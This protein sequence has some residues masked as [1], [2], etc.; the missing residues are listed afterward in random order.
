MKKIRYVNLELRLSE[1][2]VRPMSVPAW[3]VPL[4]EAVH[5]RGA[6]KQFGT[7][8]V[9]AV[10]KKRTARGTVE[11]VERMPDGAVEYARLGRRYRKSQTEDGSVG[12]AYVDVVY[13]QFGVGETNLQRAIDAASVDEADE[14]DDLIG[15]TSQVSSVG[16]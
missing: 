9:P 2:T 11:I 6:I 12:S 13:G 4:L 3:E 15:D 16:G 14:F 7:V 1:L 10:V 5:G 8:L